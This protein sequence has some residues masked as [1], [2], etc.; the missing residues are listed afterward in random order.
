VQ[1]GFL[2]ASQ[3]VQ[4]PALRLHWRSS[5]SR[6]RSR[7]DTSLGLKGCYFVSDFGG[8]EVVFLPRE[9]CPYTPPLRDWCGKQR[10][11]RES[12]WGIDCRYLEWASIEMDR[13]DDLF[14]PQRRRDGCSVV[15]GVRVEE[16]VVGQYTEDCLGLEKRVEVYVVVVWRLQ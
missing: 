12:D 4:M 1:A 3:L 5:P 7:A 8:R 15:L 6:S 16:S 13:F 14:Q 11:V 9:V 2:A 10:T